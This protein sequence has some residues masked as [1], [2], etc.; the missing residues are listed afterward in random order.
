MATH[1]KTFVG[2][3]PDKRRQGLGLETGALSPSLGGST[4]AEREG[5]EPPGPFPS[6]RF[7]RPPP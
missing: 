6:Q 2:L 1:M 4:L 3:I 7:S 5:F